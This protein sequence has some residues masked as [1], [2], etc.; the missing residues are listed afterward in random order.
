M[1]VATIQSI[2]GLNEANFES[3]AQ[4]LTSV[5]RNYISTSTQ[6]V[7]TS[8]R[9]S[10]VDVIKWWRV[11]IVTIQ[12]INDTRLPLMRSRVSDAILTYL[13]QL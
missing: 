3:S 10:S 9:L 11:V 2:K 12:S 13:I 6:K 4:N 1:I 8:R 7:A 5:H